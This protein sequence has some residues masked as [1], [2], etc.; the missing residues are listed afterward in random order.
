[1]KVYAISRGEYDEYHIIAIYSDKTKAQEVCQKFREVEPDE[2]FNV[3]EYE[4]DPDER[5]FQW[6]FV[7]MGRNFNALEA[8]RWVTK[9]PPWTVEKP[10]FDVN[11]NLLVCINTW[12]EREAVLEA[13]RLALKVFRGGQDQ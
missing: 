12:D 6:T 9:H 10:D 11:G 7:R 1:M 5:Q 2:V 13:Q 8:E 4:L 3:E